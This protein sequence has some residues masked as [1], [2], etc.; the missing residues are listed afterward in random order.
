VDETDSDDSLDEAVRFMAASVKTREGDAP[1][2]DPPQQRDPTPQKL[3]KTSFPD[4]WLQRVP[5]SPVRATCTVNRQQRKS[6]SSVSRRGERAKAGGGVRR[7]TPRRKIS[8]EDKDSSPWA[9]AGQDAYVWAMYFQVN[10]NSRFP[11][12]RDVG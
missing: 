1:P 2:P 10:S 8:P 11:L 12:S 6:P 7:H 5:P 3:L 4:R 9:Y